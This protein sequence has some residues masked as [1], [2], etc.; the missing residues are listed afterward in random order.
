MYGGKDH[1]RNLAPPPKKTVRVQRWININ[2]DGGSSTW[3]K[4]IDA[5]NCKAPNFIARLVIDE[6]VTEGDGL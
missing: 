5:D 1:E 2:A 4:E 6:L 3:D